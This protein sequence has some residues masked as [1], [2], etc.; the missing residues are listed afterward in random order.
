MQ[1]FNSGQY[2]LTRPWMRDLFVHP[3]RSSKELDS[4]EWDF[5]VSHLFLINHYCLFVCLS[6]ESR[7]PRI[8][9][10]EYCHPLFK[11]LEAPHPGIESLGSRHPGIESLGSRHSSIDSLETRCHMIGSLEFRHPRIKFLEIRKGKGKVF[12]FQE[13]TSGVL[14]QKFVFNYQLLAV[15]CRS[16]PMGSY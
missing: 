11:S 12:Y 16:N 4:K 8:E 9:S 6:F 5:F 1:G 13:H 2:A 15:I 14:P 7:H 10:L 3:K